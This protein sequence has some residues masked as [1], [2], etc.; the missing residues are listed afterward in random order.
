VQAQ[1]SDV[2]VVG[3]RLLVALTV[4]GSPTAQDRG[5]A[6][7]RWQVLTVRHG[8]IVDIVGFDDRSEAVAHTRVST[9]T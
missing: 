4:H 6:A 9:G 1:V 8:R 2:S 3:D 5:G 7:L